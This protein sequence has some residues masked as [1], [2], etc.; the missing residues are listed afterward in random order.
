ML[1]LCYLI[2]YSLNSE[3]SIDA[4]TLANIELNR[5]ISNQE[6]EERQYKNIMLFQQAG[7]VLTLFFL[8][9]G[10]SLFHNHAV[11]KQVKVLFGKNFEKP[12]QKQKIS[13]SERLTMAHPYLS[14]YDL[15]LCEMLH[16]NLTTKEIAIQLN[17]TPASVNTAR[18][19]LRK[20]L[21][22]PSGVELSAF[23]LKI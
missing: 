12:H 18:Y 10:F 9:F 22:V 5:S 13:F 19:R 17:I 20:K 14:T 11:I 21:N 7:I 3:A 15:K 4:D 16:E 6:L 23:L 1:V 2:F 8:P